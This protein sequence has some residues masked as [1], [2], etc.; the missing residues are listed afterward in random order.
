[1]HTCPPVARL[2]HSLFAHEVCP[3]T[4]VCVAVVFGA[5]SCIS[6][7]VPRVARERNSR[8]RRR[9]AQRRVRLCHQTLG[10]VVGPLKAYAHC[11]CLDVDLRTTALGRYGEVRK[12][13]R[14]ASI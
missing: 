3:L 6:F 5:H 11:C 9:D 10:M 1:M 13:A 12:N 7:R 2:H 4:Y 14:I 8:V